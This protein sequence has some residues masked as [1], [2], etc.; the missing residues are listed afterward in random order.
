MAEEAEGIL[1]QKIELGHFNLP[2]NRLAAMKTLLISRDI[3]QFQFILV[4]IDYNPHSSLLNMEKLMGLPFV[5]QLKIFITGFAM[6][7]ENL[8]SLEIS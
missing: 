4:L 6:W 7:E 5:N 8:K 1:R 2:A 3:N